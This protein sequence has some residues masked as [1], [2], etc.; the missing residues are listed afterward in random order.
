MRTLAHSGEKEPSSFIWG[1]SLR[2]NDGGSALSMLEAERAIDSAPE[3]RDHARRVFRNEVD[4]NVRSPPGQEPV[5]DWEDIEVPGVFSEEAE[6]ALI[7]ASRGELLAGRAAYY[8]QESPG[9]YASGKSVQ[10]VGASL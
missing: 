8:D 9:G 2:I 1:P 4:M 10:R 3:I 6:L 7:G 5:Y